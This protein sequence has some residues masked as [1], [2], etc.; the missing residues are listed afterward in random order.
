VELRYTLALVTG[1]GGGLG[2]EVAVA[3]S[4]RGA[5]VLVADRDGAAA[6][7]TATRVREARVKAWAFQG[8]LADEVDVRLLA[9]RA[10][11]LGGADLLVNNAGSWSPGEQFP[12]ATSAE[13]G[14]TL[15]LDLRT[16]MLLTQLFLDGLADRRGVRR[17]PG[18]VVNVASSA[19]LGASPYGS[20][21]YAAAKAGLVRFTTA[22]GGEERARVTAVVPGWI[23]LPRAHEQWAALS[24]EERAAQG[25]LVPPDDVV[26][27]VL[28]LL[29]RGLPGEVREVLG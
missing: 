16:P 3:L 14:R 12:L 22:L 2:R 28:E 10:R 29:E 17:P 6:E 24:E 27:T 7:E 4:R 1:A 13:W 11:D 19:A 15:D 23:G 26:R 21:E 20:P 18:A 25:P 8:D 5:S 9:A